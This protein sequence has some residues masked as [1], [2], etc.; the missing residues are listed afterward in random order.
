MS[1]DSNIKWRPLWKVWIPFVLFLVPLILEGQM[2][3]TSFVPYAYS[4]IIVIYGIVYY[5]RIGLWHGIAVSGMT[6]IAISW[7]F[8][9]ERPGRA[10]DSFALL[11]LDA[12]PEFMQWV[13]NY[14]T[15]PAWFMVLILNCVLYYTLGPKLLKAINLEKN[16]IRLFKLSARPIMDEG[17]GFTGRPFNMGKHSLEKNELYGLSAYLESKNICVASFPGN[18]VK[19]IFSMGISPYLKSRREELSHVFFGSNGDLSVF[20]SKHDYNQYRKQYTFDQLCEMLGKTFIRFGDYHM[21]N[22]EKRILLELRSA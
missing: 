2:I 13:I 14:I 17:N 8:L 1:V 10:F 12:S 18:G 3:G 19:F 22:N 6:A 20:I 11:G 15:T 9:A 21:S 4:L 16:A 5:Y 7:Y